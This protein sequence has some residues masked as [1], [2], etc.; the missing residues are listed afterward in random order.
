MH[1]PF[2]NTICYY[3][4]CN[5][6]ITKDHSRSAKYVRHLGLVRMN[7]QR[8][9]VPGAEGG[10]PITLQPPDSAFV[11]RF[12]LA[13]RTLDTAAAIHIPRNR[14]TVTRDDRGAMHA[15]LTA[16]PPATVD[17]W[18]VTSDG[19]LAIVRGLDYHVD[20]LDAAGA[21]SAT[22]RLSFPWERLT[23]EAK[24]AL[25]DS[26]SIE[27]AGYKTKTVDVTFDI[28]ARAFTVSSFLM[29]RW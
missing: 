23:D 13:S 8:R 24:A 12:D 10:G 3:C 27:A 16:L 21:W 2:C 19:R 28:S 1:I 14:T 29:S 4:A 25:I 7:F 22:G 6:V 17:D 26:V 5:K 9:G 20:W 11:V 18:A 15:S